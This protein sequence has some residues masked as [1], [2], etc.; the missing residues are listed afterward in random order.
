[1][2]SH[3]VNAQIQEIKSNFA[4]IITAQSNS[5]PEAVVFSHPVIFML[6]DNPDKVCSIYGINKGILL[7]DS[8]HTGIES[9]DIAALHIETLVKVKEQMEYH[10]KSNEYSR[11]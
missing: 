9:V 8:P 2:E 5:E 7:F 1:M 3:I 6:N 10:Y 11:N 4:R